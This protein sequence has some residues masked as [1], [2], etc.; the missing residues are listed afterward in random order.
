M[1]WKGFR[2]KCSWCNDMEEPIKEEKHQLEEL[3]SRLGF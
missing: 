2:R 1:E 3:V